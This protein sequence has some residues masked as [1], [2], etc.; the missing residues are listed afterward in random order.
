MVTEDTVVLAEEMADHHII[1]M[2]RQD[3]MLEEMKKTKV[4]ITDILLIT[5]F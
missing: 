5:S 4:Y 3:K 2:Q 1:S